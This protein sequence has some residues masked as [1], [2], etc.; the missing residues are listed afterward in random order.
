MPFVTPNPDRVR[1]R[2]RAR[3]QKDGKPDDVERP[4]P[5]KSTKIA[6]TVPALTE[7]VPH[8][9]LEQEVA[10]CEL[11]MLKG[12]AT[13]NRIRT[14]LGWD[15]A[16]ADRMMA[17]VRARWDI[18]GKTRSLTE[19]RGE[20]IN[21]LELMMSETWVTFQNTDDDR[22]KAVLLKTLE[23]MN[24]QMSELHGLSAKAI[25]RMMNNSKEKSTVLEGMQKQEKMVG[26]AV[27]MAML[28][29]KARRIGGDDATLVNPVVLE[30]RANGD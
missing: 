1:T 11:L 14:M 10:Q 9:R 4:V 23:S 6:G 25:Y 20:Q 3:P 5:G 15:I 28:I 12:F 21:R 17:R 30:A 7:E 19:R 26:L 27:Q 18:I 8:L 29:K 24:K 13:P 2:T 16:K 22:V